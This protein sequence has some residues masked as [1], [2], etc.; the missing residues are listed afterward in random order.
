MKAVEGIALWGKMEGLC[1]GE[2]IEFK[3]GDACSLSG[4]TTL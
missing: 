3:M 1:Y 2:I 4:G